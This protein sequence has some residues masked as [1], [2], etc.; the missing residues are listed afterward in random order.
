MKK[1]TNETCKKKRVFKGN[2]ELEVV[3]LVFIILLNNLI[4]LIDFIVLN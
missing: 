4:H 1:M 3:K 2:I